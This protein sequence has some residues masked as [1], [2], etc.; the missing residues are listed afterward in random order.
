MVNKEKQLTVKHIPKGYKWLAINP[1]GIAYAYK[2]LPTFKINGWKSDGKKKE[3]GKGYNPSNWMD[4]LI[5]LKYKEL[6]ESDI[7]EGYNWAAIGPCGFAFAFLYKPYICEILKT[8]MQEGG[9]RD[10]NFPVYTI[11][12]GYNQ[13]IWE[14]SLI[15]KE[16]N[17]KS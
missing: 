10:R 12:C 3:I 4:S 6:Q 9:D 11:G 16:N 17:K 14:D 15:L 8:W 1:D 7:P 2:S 13:S 5:G